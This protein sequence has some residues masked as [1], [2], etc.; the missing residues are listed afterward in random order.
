MKIRNTNAKVVKRVIG[1]GEEPV[2]GIIIDTSTPN[3]EKIAECYINNK[4]KYHQIAELARSLGL[5]E[6]S[7]IIQEAQKG[8]NTEHSKHGNFQSQ[9]DELNAQP[10]GLVAPATTWTGRKLTRSAGRIQGPNGPETYYN[11]NMS[12][13]VSAMRNRGYDSTNYPYWVRADGCKMLGPYIMAAANL[14]HW[15]RGSIVESSLGWTIICDTGYLSWNQL[16]IA[17]TW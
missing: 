4:D 5:P 15:P 13:V 12:R 9:L 17:V 1:A 3:L 6:D 8:W 11:L 2:D 10:T 16:D 14:N 7:A